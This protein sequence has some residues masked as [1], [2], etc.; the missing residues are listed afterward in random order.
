MNISEILVGSTLV[1]PL[2]PIEK[3]IYCGI[4]CSSIESLPDGKTKVTFKRMSGDEAF[5][6]FGD[7][8]GNIQ[9]GNWITCKDLESVIE[10]CRNLELS[11]ENDKQTILVADKNLKDSLLK[12]DEILKESVS[13][14]EKR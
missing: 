9:L 11:I 1:T 2:I 5:S 6:F 7:Q 14:K 4:V 13:T 10:S 3:A 8:Q 12:R